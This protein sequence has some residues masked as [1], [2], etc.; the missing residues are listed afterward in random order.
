MKKKYL[1]FGIVIVILILALAILTLYNLQSEDVEYHENISIAITGD[2]MFARKMPSVLDS[3]V[4]PFKNVKNVTSSADLLL[5]NFEN[6]AT[7]AELNYKHTIP[8]KSN[9]KYTHL[10]KAN[11]KTVVAL[12]NNHIFDYGDIG[13]EDTIKTLKENDILYLGAGHN[14]D[15]ATKPVTLEIKDRKI[16]IL[17]YMD[18]NN[19]KEFSQSELPI[20][21]KNSSGYAPINWDIIQ[22][23]LTENNDSDM[24]IVFLH[25]GNEYSRTPNNNQVDISHKLIDNGADIV[26]GAHPHVSQGI[27]TY[28]NKTI[29]Y[30]LGNFIFDQSNP[31]THIA[32]FLELKL[33]NS[34]CEIIVHPIYIS[35]YLPTFMDASSAQQLLV[36]LNP[37][38]T[39]MNIT[40]SGKGILS[41]SLDN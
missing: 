25:Y 34:E 4:D 37:Q 20:S 32:M 12:S 9:P 33:V 27:E 13:Y 15:E 29:F 1:S 28:K 10:A 18:Q 36:G 39:K 8:I 16:T 31:A 7:N 26:V 3:G 19:F 22:K 35:N 23:D 38:P 17:N 6:P 21:T 24:V 41:F 40:S 5:L 14:I 2:V 30:S 11:N